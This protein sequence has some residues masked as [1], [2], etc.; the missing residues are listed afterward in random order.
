MIFRGIIPCHL[1]ASILLTFTFP[2][3][4][5]FGDFNQFNQA[6]MYNN[7]GSLTE[8]DDMSFTTN[9]RKRSID[10]GFGTTTTAFSY[11]SPIY[12]GKY[13]IDRFGALG[14]TVFNEQAGSN[15]MLKMQGAMAGLALSADLTP[16]LKLSFGAQVGYKTRK[17]DVSNITTDSQF[18]LEG[19]DPS[20]DIGEIFNIRK[21]TAMTI[22]SGLK[23]YIIDKDQ[24]VRG[25]FGFAIFN[26]DRGEIAFTDALDF[27]IRRYVTMAGYRVVKIWDI[28]IIPNI[29]SV[30]QE[31]QDQF[32]YGLTIQ[33]F[34][35]IKDHDQ[36]GKFALNAWLNF[37]NTFIFSFEYC[38]KHLTFSV[39]YDIPFSDKVSSKLANNALEV[40]LGWKFMNVMNK[41]INRA[42]SS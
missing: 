41:K 35:K 8:K 34:Y 36:E 29:R 11:I 9:Y 21:K 31:K 22:S 28:E 18:G 39:G 4:G 25:Y 23:W 20:R 16:G 1:L 32:N 38:H 3:L 14:I 37:E 19:Y 33:K 13:S 42:K 17:I 10:S 15:G 24:R 26:L 6:L 30:R 7:P 40:S 5:Q 2:V 27:L 12:K